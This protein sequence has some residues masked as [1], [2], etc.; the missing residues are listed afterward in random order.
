MVLELIFITLASFHQR[1]LVP[2]V[3]ASS[4]SNI[5]LFCGE[6]RHSNNNFFLYGHG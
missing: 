3:V 4:F 6:C 5:V 1:I 2:S